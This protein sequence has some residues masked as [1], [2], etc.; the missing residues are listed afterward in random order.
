MPG[1]IPL[2]MAGAVTYTSSRVENATALLYNFTTSCDY[3]ALPSDCTARILPSQINAFMSELLN[4]AATL[5]PSGE[6]DC[7][8]LDNLGRLFDHY[9]T[10]TGVGRNLFND[11]QALICGV[12]QSNPGPNARYLYCDGNGEIHKSVVPFTGLEVAQ[13][14]CADP[15]AAQTLAACLVSTTQ[16]G[17]TLQVHA[18]GDGLLGVKQHRLYGQEAI[19]PTIGSDIIGQDPFIT[20][21]GAAIT[22]PNGSSNAIP[23]MLS[24][25]LQGKA[26]QNGATQNGYG[27]LTGSLFDDPA[28]T[29]S[30]I[31]GQIEVNNNDNTG[32]IQ[33]PSLE[34][35]NSNSRIVN[36]PAGGLTLYPGFEIGALPDASIRFD[37]IQLNV[38]WYGYGVP[39]S[40]N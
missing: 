20:R 31:F 10:N 5:V 13:A 8:S 40:A 4:F 36:V 1:I 24:L 19:V 33:P 28:R 27:R 17:Q 6:W 34:F 15:D 30:L 11:L 25:D 2:S 21:N 3:L 38:T 9:R 23:V 29:N 37:S 16:P 12:T 22:I 26:R 14:I 32:P 18:A 35:N 7:D 39:G